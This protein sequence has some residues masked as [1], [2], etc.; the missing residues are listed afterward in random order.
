MI[1]RILKA[2]N[3]NLPLEQRST[4][5]DWC[6]DHSNKVEINESNLENMANTNLCFGF[7]G[8]TQ[9]VN[10]DQSTEDRATE[11][12]LRLL[13]TLLGFNIHLPQ[14]TGGRRVLKTTRGIVTDRHL[15][16]LWILKRII[17]LCPD[18][19]SAIIEIGAGL[20]LL[21]YYLDKAGYKDY[22]SIDLATPGACQSY[23]LSKNLPERNIILSGDDIDDR[24]SLKLLHS[25]DFKNMP[26]DRFDI[27]INI[28]SL[29]EMIPNEIIKYVSSDCAKL[30]LSINTSDVVSPYR[31]KLYSIPFR[32]RDNYFEE[33]FVYE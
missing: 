2:F 24:E 28:D 26:K 6:L 8:G 19:D 1:E 30:L 32:L 23:F 27:M 16:Y 31:K 15:H 33:L 20:G 25:T 17:Q 3:K 10:T 29:P 7:F 5:W 4:I 14:F 9:E 21:G 13:E 22:T 18:K 12:M 11:T